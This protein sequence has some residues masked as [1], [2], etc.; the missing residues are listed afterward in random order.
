MIATADSDIKIDKLAD[1]IKAGPI[2]PS[3][4]VCFS[5]TP[6]GNETEGIGSLSFYWT[7]E[8]RSKIAARLK[9]AQE[10]QSNLTKETIDSLGDPLKMVATRTAEACKQYIISTD[11][12]A[13][14]D[15]NKF[16]LLV[17]PRRSED[18]KALRELESSLIAYKIASTY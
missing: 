1:D 17:G 15:P 6:N 12:F 2:K 10:I 18:P 4:T 8:D 11:F 3:T 14:E 16:N 9:L 13:F 7:P 5:S